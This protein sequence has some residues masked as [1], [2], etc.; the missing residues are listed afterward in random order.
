[1]RAGSARTDG[2]DVDQNQ[3]KI[4]SRS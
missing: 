1:V 4:H 3:E 2:R